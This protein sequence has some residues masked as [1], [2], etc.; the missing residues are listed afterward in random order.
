MIRAA[1]I[2]LTGL[3]LAAPVVAQ[4]RVLSDGEVLALADRQAL[5]CES[6]S[7]ETRDC[8]SLYT[9]R[10]ESDGRLVLA[11]MF[12]LTSRPL[13][14]V[15]VAKVVTLEEGR[16]CSSGSTDDLNVR[17][18]LAGAPSPEM[19]AM[20]RGLYAVRMADYV[21]STICQQF[22]ATGDPAVMGEIITAD[23]IRQQDFESTYRLGDF[24]SG[25]LLRPQ[26]GDEREAGMIDL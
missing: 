26:I 7:D 1:F 24:D 6:W 21:E 22:I 20:V 14:E 5:W 15:T 18:T 10:R 11:G 16:L 2:L 25:F 17:A 9:L 19:S 4:E 3:A 8:E 23:D 13:V 12:V